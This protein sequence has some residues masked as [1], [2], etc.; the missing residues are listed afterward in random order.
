[1]AMI[2]NGIRASHVYQDGQA[3]SGVKISVKLGLL[4]DKVRIERDTRT[5]DPYD[6]LGHNPISVDVITLH[7][8]HRGRTYATV[9]H[10]LQTG[11]RGAF[12]LDTSKE[13]GRALAKEFAPLLASRK[14]NFVTSLMKTRIPED[15]D[16]D[17]KSV[18]AQ[19]ILELKQPEKLFSTARER[20]AKAPAVLTEDGAIKLKVSK[21]DRVLAVFERGHSAFQ[22]RSVAR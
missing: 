20:I 19:A 4:V 2:G 12:D 15:F 13:R 8:P 21:T 17:F 22:S 18:L 9:S 5:V 14:A 16:Y 3:D 6:N 7:M 1:M 11:A 10:H